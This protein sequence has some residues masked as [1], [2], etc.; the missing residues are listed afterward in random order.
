MC[1]L[2]HFYMNLVFNLFFKPHCNEHKSFSFI[3]C[4]KNEKV[5]IIIFFLSKWNIAIHFSLYVVQLW[6][7][8][9]N[10]SVCIWQQI[11]EGLKAA[12]NFEH[13]DLPE[14]SIC[15]YLYVCVCLCVHAHICVCI[16]FI[17]LFYIKIAGI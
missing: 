8:P 10:W 12:W 13:T 2:I 4:F 15:N 9:E 7:F 17:S 11:G 16:W 1:M 14:K 6:L 5:T 3:D